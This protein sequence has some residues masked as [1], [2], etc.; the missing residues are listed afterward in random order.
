MSGEV[1]CCSVGDALLPERYL[2]AFDVSLDIQC[3]PQKCLLRCLIIFPSLCLLVVL[4]DGKAQGSERGQGVLW[5]L[6]TWP[7]VGK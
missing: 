2:S 6:R 1:V 4:F 3:Y 5:G 7:S